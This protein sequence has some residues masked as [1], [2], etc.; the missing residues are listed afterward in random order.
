MNNLHEVERWGTFELALDCTHKEGVTIEDYPLGNAL[1]RK[2]SRKI[3]AGFFRDINGVTRVRFMPDEEG[4]WHYE[5]YGGFID[6]IMGQSNGRIHCTAPGP[7]NHGPVD[8]GG[9][10]QDFCYADGTAFFPFGTTCLQGYAGDQAEQ[11]LSALTG[12][13]FNKVRFSMSSGG[14]STDFASLEQMILQLM[15]LGI[16]V[17]LLLNLGNGESDEAFSNLFSQTIARL[18]AY[19]NVW[20]SLPT[21]GDCYRFNKDEVLRLVQQNDPYGH[22]LTVHSSDPLFNFGHKA[23]THVSLQCSDPSQLTY[24]A[25]LHHKPIIVEECGCEGDWPTLWG[26]LPGEEVVNR[27]WASACRKGFAS[28]G[29]KYMRDGVGTWQT[30]GGALIGSAVPRIAFL[31]SILEDAPAGLRFM[32]EYYDAATIGRDGEYYLQFYGIHRFPSKQ[33]LLPDGSYEVDIID[34]WNM[35][36]NTLPGTYKGD[37][38]VTLPS[39]M[40]HALRVRRL[41]KQPFSQERTSNIPFLIRS[42]EADDNFI[43]KAEK[44]GGRNGG[45]AQ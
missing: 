39:L 37:V 26:S 11:T 5:L 34:T 10:K 43:R 4:E 27:M 20:W 13:P 23:I 30:H 32:P 42:A 33:L 28:Y 44:P 1:F 21:E 24:F 7:N 2:G 9:S 45:E 18:A 19:R 16:E 12:S 38:I 15:K 3:A 35:T 29:E 17:D 41:D 6:T 14:N 36:I 8:V 25:G 40:Y 22:L 31:R